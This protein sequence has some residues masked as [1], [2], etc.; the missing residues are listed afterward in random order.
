MD[1]LELPQI[2]PEMLQS[3]PKEA[4]KYVAAL[5]QLLE[6]LLLQNQ[7][8][9]QRLWKLSYNEAP[10]LIRSNRSTA[11]FELEKFYFS[12]NQSVNL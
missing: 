11:Q 8:L 7:Q 9:L 1:K 2:P 10:R 3:W 4:Q 6:Q 5:Q 12:T